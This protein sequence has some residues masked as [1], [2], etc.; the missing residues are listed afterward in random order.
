M[1]NEPALSMED[2]VFRFY[3]HGKR[4]ILDHVSLSIEPGKL[5]VIMGSSGCGKSTLAAVAAGLYP[6][7]GGF[8][9]QGK[10]S[11]FGH[12]V[13]DMDPR[14]RAAYL[15]LLFQNPDLQF[16]MDTLR[17]ELY[18]CMENMCMPPDEMEEKAREAAR[19]MGVLPLLDRPLHTLSGGEKQRAS[20]C[21]LALLGSRCIVLDEA[22]ANLDEAAARS[23]VRQVA[24]MKEQGITVIAID[25]QLELWREAADEIIVLGEGARVLQRG[26]TRENLS[27]YMPLFLAEGLS[28]PEESPKKEPFGAG[29]EMAVSFSHV[30]VPAEVIKKRF[31]KPQFG[32]ILLSDVTTGFPKGR[33]TAILGE[34]GSGKT[35]ALMAILKNHP[36]TGS[37]CVNGRDIA[38]M[39]KRELFHQAGIVFQNPA[40]QFITQNVEQEVRCSVLA[41]NRGCPEEEAGRIT[42]EALRA[43]GLWQHRRYSPYMLSQGQ[44]RRLAVLSV[45]SGGQRILFLDEP[46]Y[47]QDHKS[48]HAIMQQL[49]E[50]TRREGLTVIFIT[51]DQGLADRWADHIVW[52][53]DRKFIPEPQGE[54]QHGA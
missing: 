38:G 2:V 35:T 54:G 13:E 52:L 26:I 28:Y 20:L 4:N 53:K 49:Y 15:S 39:T 18:F 32:R 24:A 14:T 21:C 31:K 23:L 3:E 5:T 12:P 9:I 8:L 47:G 33:M 17:K 19:R 6:E 30:T 48:T 40:N 51:H 45:L 34:S 46:T 7:N 22:F 37:I 1:S 27:S 50:K 42:E 43:Y 41:W 36:Y 10:I 16:C 25:H 44:Q 29:Q 11:L